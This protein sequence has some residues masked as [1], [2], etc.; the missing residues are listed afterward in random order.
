MDPG[1]KHPSWAKHRKQSVRHTSPVR[2]PYSQ[3]ISIAAP[4]LA[5]ELLRYVSSNLIV[6][7]T[8]A[9]C[10]AREPFSTQPLLP[11]LRPD[12]SSANTTYDS[13]ELPRLLDHGLSQIKPTSRENLPNSS[14]RQTIKPT[15]GCEVAQPPETEEALLYE[16]MKQHLL[17]ILLKPPENSRASSIR[18][19]DRLALQSTAPEK[20]LLN[21]IRPRQRAGVLAQRRVVMEPLITASPNMRRK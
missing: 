7:S 5:A 19:A 9:D 12:T 3:R 4:D 10:P 17:Q 14:G 18:A 1:R 8:F 15:S 21:L 6:M 13:A 2:A 16:Q 11:D 20:S